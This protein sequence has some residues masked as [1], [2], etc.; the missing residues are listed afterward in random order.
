MKATVFPGRVSGKVIIPPSKSMAHRSIICAAL[1]DGISTITN[2]AYS[3][4]IIAT[5]NAMRALGAKIEENGSTLKIVGVNNR[6]HP[7]E[8]TVDAHESGSTLRFIIPLFSLSNKPITFLGHNRL[9]YRP[10][11]VYKNLFEERG[12][13]FSQT[14]EHLDIEG[15]LTSGVYTIDGSISSQFISGLLFTLPLL[16][17]DSSIEITP[18]FESESYVELTLSLLKTFGIEVEHP[19]PLT[20]L[21]KGNQHYKATDYRVEGDYSQLAFHAVLAAL[22]NDLELVD[23]DLNSRQGDKAIIQILK[24]CGVKIEEL[25]NGYRVYKSPLHSTTIDLADCPD[26]GPILCVLGAFCKELTIRNCSRLRLKES[27]RI[28]AMEEALRPLGVDITSDENNIYLKGCKDYHGGNEVNGAKDHRIVMSMAVMAT[29]LDAPLCI[30]SAE[31]I[32][33][34][35]PTFFTH[36]ESLGIEVKIDD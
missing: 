25:A 10:Q 36:L 19:T 16:D 8:T 12:L 18:P 22:N 2:I 34:S 20:Y 5:I 3:D 14:H 27:D 6:I 4:D 15:A 21:I 24:D 17:G 28:A 31:A 32:N 30:T 23:V 35:Y 11:D 13:S 1:A 33:K 26:L 29:L 7:L 9:L